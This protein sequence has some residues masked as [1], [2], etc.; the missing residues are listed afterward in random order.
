MTYP[1]YGLNFVI[2]NILGK[3]L[4]KRYANFLFQIYIRPLS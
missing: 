1:P 4:E 3:S 2:V